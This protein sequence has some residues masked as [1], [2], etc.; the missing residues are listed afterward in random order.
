MMNLQDL[1]ATDDGEERENGATCK[2]CGR[3]AGGKPFLPQLRLAGAGTAVRRR[4]P[5]GGAAGG[6]YSE[7]GVIYANYPP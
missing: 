5:G 3:C 7:Y 4:R 6:I 2:R 1:N